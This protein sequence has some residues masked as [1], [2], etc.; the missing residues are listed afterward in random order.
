MGADIYLNSIYKP[1]L[2]KAEPKF[3]KACA[4]REKAFPRG[5]P[6]TA[7]RQAEYDKLQEAVD[8]AFDGLHPEGG[9][10][11]DSYNDSSLFWVLGLSWWELA[12][13]L[14]TTDEE[15]GTILPIHG[16]RSLLVRIEALP[17]TAERFARWEE[18][19]RANGWTFT[20]PEG[21]SAAEWKRDFVKRRAQFLTMLRTS[22]YL[23]EPLHWSV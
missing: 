2:A 4:A 3:R 5:A 6:V 20:K 14:C 13:E 7:E 15:T 8:K 11:R 1:A 12:K 21:S 17:V 23:N 18:K 9:Y 16:A 22:I 19:A 10:F